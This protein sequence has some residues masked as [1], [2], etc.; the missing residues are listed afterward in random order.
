MGIP[1]FPTRNKPCGWEFCG[2]IKVLIFKF[3]GT[4][5]NYMR[6]KNE[7]FSVEIRECVENKVKYITAKLEG[8]FEISDTGIIWWR[9]SGS[10]HISVLM[11]K[12]WRQSQGRPVGEKKKREREKYNFK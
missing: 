6:K 1:K 9:R 8:H 11:S 4:N 5:T 3:M 7:K 12:C 2:R 10:F